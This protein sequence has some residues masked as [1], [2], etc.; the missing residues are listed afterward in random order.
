MIILDELPFM[1]VE[2]YGFRRFVKVL[3]PKFKMI[4][5]HKTIAKEVV[6]I[7]NIKREKLKKA[8]GVVGCALPLTHGLQFKIFVICVLLVILLIMIGS[9]I[10]EF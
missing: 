1:F 6:K 4:P 9:C 5:S 10:K 3:Q 2:N 8:L 7:Y